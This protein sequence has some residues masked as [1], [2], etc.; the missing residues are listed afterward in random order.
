MTFYI[1]LYAYAM[2]ATFARSLRP[3]FDIKSI[4]VISF[5]IT[6][7]LLIHKQPIMKTYAEAAVWAKLPNPPSEDELKPAFKSAYY[8]GLNEHPSFGY[9]SKLSAREWWIITVKK[10]LENC[11]RTYTETEFN[12]YFRRIYQHYGSTDGYETLP[13]AVDFLK[14]TKEKNLFKE[15]LGI[16]TNTPHRSVETVL[17]MVGLHEYFNW[18]VCCHDCGA[19]KPDKKIFEAFH[20][21]A[22]FWQP[23]LKKEEILHIGDNFSTDYCGARAAGFHAL[24][25]DRSKNPRVTN[26]QDWVKAP[27]YPGKSTE[28]I[29]RN[30]IQDFSQLKQLISSSL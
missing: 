26:Y 11:G 2:A 10:A 22:L 27:D 17:P 25:L 24:H 7:T 12:R 20:Q 16:C 18:F 1:R 29:E 8:Q 30:T 23:N 6:G 4:K 9:H 13:D 21:A 15:S 14:W 28:D 5:D 19:E 3:N